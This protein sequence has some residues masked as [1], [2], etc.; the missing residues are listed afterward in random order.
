MAASSSPTEVLMSDEFVICAGCVLLRRLPTLQVCILYHAKEDRYI[1]PKGR[2]DRGESIQETALRETYEETGHRCSFLPLNMKTRS[3]PS[4]VFVKDQPTY[5]IGAVEPVAVFLR[6][7]A[8]K[9]V[10]FIFWFVA[11]VDETHPHEKGTQIGSEDYET[12]FAPAAEVLDVLTY[13]CD[14]EAVAKALELYHH[15]YPAN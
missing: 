6:R 11:E 7:V 13:A 5:A 14:R 3:Q 2:K 8:D 1:L 15:T 10:K 12:H 4:N 9:D